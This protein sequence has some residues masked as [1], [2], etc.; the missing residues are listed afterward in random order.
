MVSIDDLIT[1]FRR[2]RGSAVH[3]LGEGTRALTYWRQ[4]KRSLPWWRVRARREADRM[5]RSWDGHLLR[6]LVTDLSAP[7]P[8]RV[9][10]GVAL[11]GWRTRRWLA[12]MAVRVGAGVAVCTAAGAA[13]AVLLIH[14]L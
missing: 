13:F 5:L 12:R 6:A 8:D 1:E 9:Q 2:G 4:R 11:A 3:D 14:F 10:A 7:L